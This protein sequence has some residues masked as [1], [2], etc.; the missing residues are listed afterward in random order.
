MDDSKDYN[1]FTLNKI[2]DF[3]WEPFDEVLSRSFI[4]YGVDGR[5]FYN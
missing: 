2:D 5:G 3:V 4:F 1:L